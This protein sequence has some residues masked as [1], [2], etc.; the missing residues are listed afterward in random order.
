[1]T[2]GDGVNG[3]RVPAGFRNVVALLYRVGGGSAGGVDAGAVRTMLTSVPFVTGVTNPLAASGGTDVEP[4]ERV[5]RRGPKEIRAR[6]R[7]VTVADYELL[8]VSAPGAQIARAHA[9]AGLHPSHPGPPMPGIVGVFVVPPD[10]GEG[11]PTPDEG[12]LRNVAKYLS[13]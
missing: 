6:G 5:L 8:A 7:A 11:P 1:M 2:F 3:R 9:V 4:V 10:R 12:S 13:E